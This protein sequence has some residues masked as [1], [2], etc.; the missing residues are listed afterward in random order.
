MLFFIAIMAV[1]CEEDI[2]QRIELLDSQ[3]SS[4]EAEVDR[5][6]SSGGIASTEYLNKYAELMSRYHQMRVHLEQN[7]ILPPKEYNILS[8]LKDLRPILAGNYHLS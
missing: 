4:L 2:R 5:S 6:L 8:R 3:L 7:H 1:I